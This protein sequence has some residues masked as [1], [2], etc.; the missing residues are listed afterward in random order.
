MV[1]A[2]EA[3]DHMTDRNRAQC[4]L[5][6]I[7]GNV[8]TTDLIGN[9]VKALLIIRPVG[10]AARATRLINRQSEIL[11]YDSPVTNSGRNAA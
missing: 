1:H 6:L 11:R 9:G 10:E 2:E 4:N 8:T 7:A 3:G 5:L